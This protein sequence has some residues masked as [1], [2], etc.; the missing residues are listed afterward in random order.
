MSQTLR[1]LALALGRGASL[2]A[3]TATLAARFGARPALRG[4]APLPGLTSG[5]PTL[6]FAALE[7]AVARLA[8]AHE[9][10]GHA[11][12]AHVGVCVDNRL[13]VLLHV[14]A[15]ARAGAVA[16]P[17]NPRLRPGELEEVLAAAR[18][19][20][21]LADP[22]RGG[23]D[24]ASPAPRPPR[25]DSDALAAWL[26]AH[27]TARLGPTD[28][29]APDDVAVLLCTSGTTGRP[30][31]AA[32][33]SAGLVGQAGRLGLV[34]VGAAA[35]P[36][37]HRDRVLCPLPLTHVM[38][39]SVLLGAL[40]AGVEAIHVGHFEP[41][42]VLETL[43][44]TR[45]NV[46]VGV[47]TMY[48]DLEPLAD[49]FDL[50]HVQLWISSADA[51]PPDR[52][53]RFQRRGAAACLRGRPVGTAAFLDVYGMV[54]LSGPMAV[55]V[56]PPSPSGHLTMPRLT[57][58]LPGFEARAVDED[59]RP[60]RLGRPGLLEVRGPGVLRRY[61]GA[62]SGPGADGWFR[63]GDLA[64]VWPGGFF[65]LAGRSRDRLKVG[66][67]SV[68]PAEVEAA[69]RAHPDV[70][71]VA[72]VGLPDARLGERPVALV[73]PREGGLRE[74]EFLAWAEAHV[75]GYRRPRQVLRVDALPRGRHGK[76]DRAAATR[77]AAELAAS[78]ARA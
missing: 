57:R 48:A 30:K 24:D 20:A 68:F 18:V 16:V 22:G 43:E 50:R 34:P 55:R 10:H 71:E 36:R 51:M 53:R 31:A 32:L 46:F 5:P 67:F 62:A 73:V 72:V 40:C 70:A 12:G 21:L 66:G 1:S 19:T 29:L 37:A 2:G 8:A 33:T 64:R 35:G 60:A 58:V 14:L 78:V 49:G 39:L 65:S 63:T 77:V 4:D 13:D 61:E 45:A 11:A 38:G 76:L 59:G 54:E 9:A 69:L 17:I 26:D 41:R 3:L 44:A 47:P 23:L 74:D 52:A 56:Y 15:L 42:A 27:P 25:L 28:R 6:T 75:A 7:D